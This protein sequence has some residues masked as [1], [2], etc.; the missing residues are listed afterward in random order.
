MTALSV[1]ARR[2]IAQGLIRWWSQRLVETPN[3]TKAD[4]YDPGGDTGAVADADDWVDTHSGNICNT[5]G[6]NGALSQPFRDEATSD[7]KGELLL[8]VAAVRIDATGDIARRIVQT[9]VD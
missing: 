3:L 8:V 5:I 7:M 4:I 6:Y 2:K 1:A 9:E